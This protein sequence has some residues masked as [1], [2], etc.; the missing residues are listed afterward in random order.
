MKITIKSILKE[1][2]NV[3]EEEAYQKFLKGVAKR[4]K[5]PYIKNMKVYDVPELDWDEVFN[6]IFGVD[7]YVYSSNDKYEVFDN[8]NNNILYAEDF[9]LYVRDEPLY[10]GWR[11]YEYNNKHFPLEWTY[12][13]MSDNTFAK[14]EFNDLG[15][16]IYWEDE[17][18][19]GIDKRNKIDDRKEIFR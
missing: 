14:R 15:E 1:N 16:I 13:E 10:V 2:I 12:V 7:V 4:I 9:Q 17:N 18:G 11:M 8:I 3:R 6:E 5:P 19:V